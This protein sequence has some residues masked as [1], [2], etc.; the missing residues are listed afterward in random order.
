MQVYAVG[1]AIRDELLG[2]PSQDRDYV[3]VGATP[4]DMEAAGYKP[5]GKDFPV[6][7]H[8][9]TKEE[10]ALA[11]T[12]R[13]TAM[14]YKGFA[15]YCEPDVTLDDDLVRRDL[16][17]NAMA[18]A[19]DDDGKLVGPVIDP[20]GGQRDL[21]ARQFRHVSE[22]FAEDPVRILR[23]ARFAARFHDFTVAPET[24]ALMR[25]MVDAGEVDALVPERV[26]QELARGL[27]EARPARMFEVLRQCGALA[28]LLPELD[29]LW[30]VPQRADYHPEVDTGVHVMMV[31][32]CA[33][34]MGTTLAVRFA[35]LVH[36]LGKGTTPEHVLPRHLGHETRSV[37]LLEDVCKR[38]R[39]PNDCRDLAVVVAREHGNIHR[40]M[41]FGA[42]AITRLLERCDALR[43]PGRFADALLACEADKRGRKG[44]ESDTYPQKARLLAALD[45]A[46]SVD[47]GAIAKALADD[48]SK[49]RER[50]H[51][52]RV[53]AV[54]AR[55]KQLA[56]H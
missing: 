19:V 40:S 46:A 35:A 17:I 47:A 49:I 10:Y 13:K 26:W 5:V 33:A 27:M 8:P 52:A 20:H 16:T 23:V 38:L 25:R 28:R 32:D 50:V 9:R 6:F 30:G 14:G 54:D 18:R 34:A 4:A 56:D 43:K 2:K 51:E 29:R 45:A 3:V 31:I 55:L 41:E 24:V 21:A 11:R 42:A 36:D 15:F 7:L 48:V 22:A 1:G 44:F 37:E 53:A 39:V 12:E